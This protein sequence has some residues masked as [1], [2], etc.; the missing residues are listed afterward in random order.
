MFSRAVKKLCNDYSPQDLHYYSVAGGT[1]KIGEFDFQPVAAKR[2]TVCDLDVKLLTRSRP[3]V[4]NQDGDLDN[5][6]KTLFDALRVPTLAELPAN[7]KPTADEHLFYV[8]LED[9]SSIT[10]LRIRSEHLFL[11]P[12]RDEP[13]GYAELY[14]EVKLRS[15]R[16]F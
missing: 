4:L 12:M 6:L 16:Q 2:L 13:N 10:D 14:V 3:G 8:L 7:E 1:I 5:R 15:A 9:D 11:A